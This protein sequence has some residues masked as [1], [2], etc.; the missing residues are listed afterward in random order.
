MQ[1]MGHE[2]MRDADWTWPATGIPGAA[3]ALGAVAVLALGLA[4][5]MRG[6]FGS[7]WYFDV[8]LVGGAIPSAV[9]F[10][11]A[12]AVVAGAF[13]WPATRPWLLIA[14]GLLALHGL[15]DLAMDVWLAWWLNFSADPSQSL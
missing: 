7:S 10:V 1:P 13:R 4:T 5:V 8:G 12:A 11:I 9:P 14:A 2:P 3:W 6:F 15:L